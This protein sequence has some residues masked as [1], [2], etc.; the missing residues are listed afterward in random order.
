MLVK[1]KSTK[2]Y[3]QDNETDSKI[4]QKVKCVLIVHTCMEE[5]HRYL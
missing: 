2:N 5:Q 4:T 3:S 1:N